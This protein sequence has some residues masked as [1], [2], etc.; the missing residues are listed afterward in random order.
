MQTVIALGTFDGMHAGHRRV[1][2]RTVEEARKTGAKSMVYTFTGIPRTLFGKTARMLMTPE[3]RRQAMLDMGVDEVVMVEFTEDFAAISPEA[4]I[5]NLK[6]AYHPRAVVAGEDYSF[7]CKA[8]GKKDTLIKLGKE[9][10]FEAII[11]PVVRVVM[12]DGTEGE[13][14]SST[15]IRQAIEENRPELARQIAKGNRTE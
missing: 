15:G 14:I 4:F 12:P 6:N 11:V 13:K 5:E 7:G 1:I 9:M 3:E 8:A 2:S 10:G